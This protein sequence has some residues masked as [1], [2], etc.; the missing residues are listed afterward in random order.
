MASEEKHIACE[1]VKAGKRLADLGLIVASDGN[2]SARIGKEGILTTPTGEPKGGLSPAHLVR[3]SLDGRVIGQGSPSSEIRMHLGIYRLRPDAQA[4]V[5]AHPPFAT[6]FAVAGIGLTK[7]ILPEAVL[8]LGPVPLV[9]YATPG[10]QEVPHKLAPYLSSKWGRGFRYHAFLLSNH[11][12]VTLGS[13]LEEAL[14]RMERV[15]LLAR[16]TY[17]ARQVG[18]VRTLRKSQEKALLRVFGQGR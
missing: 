18:K 8:S 16:V 1:M 4:V 17:L 14:F 5:H 10:T 13:S 3:V 7:P 11:G 2:I 12:A 9:P 6:A 15:E